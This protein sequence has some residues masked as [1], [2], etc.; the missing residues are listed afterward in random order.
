MRC[1]EKWGY[2]AAFATHTYRQKMSNDS[3]E[4]ERLVR[5]HGADGCVL[6]IYIAPVATT[7]LTSVASVRAVPAKGLEGDRYF[8]ARGTFS[9]PKPDRE[10]TL[11]ESEA[12]E[13]LAH[14]YGTRIDPGAS[15]R[16]IVTRD[17]ALNHLVGATFRV[18]E[19]TLRGLGLCEP[20]EHL[21]ELTNPRVFSGLVHR[22][23]L[24]AQILSEGVIHVG[25]SIVC[26]DAPATASTAQRR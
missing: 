14:D 20:C 18:G 10:V 17:V 16:N 6:G 21:A 19:V 8:H 12:I 11:I 25:D 22:G 24:R 3:L 9:K 4:R 15:R 2:N 26:V 13:A 23:G 5:K 7:P 1:Q